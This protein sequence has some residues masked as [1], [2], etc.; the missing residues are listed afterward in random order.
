MF[1]SAV[2]LKGKKL[3]RAQK[4]ADLKCDKTVTI[5]TQT[6]ADV[7]KELLLKTQNDVQVKSK[8]FIDIDK[9]NFRIKIDR[10]HYTHGQLLEQFSTVSKEE[11]IENNYELPDE[12]DY[13]IPK[14]S[15]TSPAEESFRLPV[16]R[17]S[18]DSLASTRSPMSFQRHNSTMRSIKME[19]KSTWFVV[20]NYITSFIQNSFKFENPRAFIKE[21]I[22]LYN[23]LPKYFTKNRRENILWDLPAGFINGLTGIPEAISFALVAGISP[24]NGI[25][26][27]MFPPM[28][29]F[30]FGSSKH[31]CIG[32]YSLTTLITG[33]ALK[34]WAPDE[35]HTYHSNYSSMAWCSLVPESV[36]SFEVSNNFM[37]LRKSYGR[38]SS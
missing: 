37:T 18:Q 6:I 15:I 1:S 34:T 30:V 20:F 7:A 12:T 35:S 10:K 9:K 23:W 36:T 11:F 27:M 29:Y 17:A 22:P 24:Q 19:K 25:A 2:K 14:I 13:I 4:R 32:M 26:T 31:A 21:K 33:I 38:C 16:R 28:V 3:F 8:E 5:K